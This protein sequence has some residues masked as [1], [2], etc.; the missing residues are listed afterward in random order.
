M[1]NTED[2]VRTRTKVDTAREGGIFKVLIF[3]ILFVVISLTAYTAYLRSTNTGEID[4]RESVSSMLSGLLTGQGD[5]YNAGTKLSSIDYVAKER[6]SFAVYNNMIIKCNVNG[7]SAMNRNGNEQ[8]SVSAIINK[9]VAKTGGQNVIVADIG[10]RQVFVV[11]DKGLKWEKSMEGDIINADINREGYVTVVHKREGYKGVVKVFTPG[12]KEIFERAIAD[13]YVFYGNVMPSGET[14]IIQGIDA[15][16]IEAASHFEFTDLRGNPFAAIIPSEK[17]VYPFVFAF[18]NDS[19]VLLDDTTIVYFDKN[20]N[21]M[22]ENEYQKIY[23]AG[24]MN[25]E[26]IIAA[27]KDRQTEGVCDVVVMN[28]SGTVTSRYPL[29]EKVYGIDT[30]DDIAAVNTGREVYFIN[31]RGNLFL[32][33][34]S[35]SDITEVLFFNRNEAALVTN[36]NI[37]IIKIR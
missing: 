5:T 12:G 34:S 22:W 27:V 15:S 8:W 13:S 17:R 25:G 20:R 36:S 2:K 14:V 10:G 3:L 1:N 29:D 18:E 30:Y 23:G 9:P 26:Y 31:S 4:I 32:T 35:I 16:G 24:I 37:E 11:D 7:I 33:Y 6:P 19:F 28:K 21:K